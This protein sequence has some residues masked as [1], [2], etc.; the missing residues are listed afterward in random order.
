MNMEVAVFS[1]GVW[2]EN[3]IIPTGVLPVTRK[4]EYSIR[5][6]PP[7]DYK[8]SGFEPRKIQGFFNLERRVCVCVCFLIG[9]ACYSE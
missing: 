1:L 4:V 8:V 5:S 7:Q 3:E 6:L 9:D 2:G